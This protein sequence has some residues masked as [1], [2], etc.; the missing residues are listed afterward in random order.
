MNSSVQISVP[1]LD[2]K[3]FLRW[4]AQM[5]VLFDYHE[6]LSIVESGVPE[7]EAKAS[8]GK[9]NIHREN[10]KNDKKALFLIH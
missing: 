10:K 6:L 5:K 1:I 4:N 8:D 9:K 3:N 2:G 7:L